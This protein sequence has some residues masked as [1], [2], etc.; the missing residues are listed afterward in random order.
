MRMLCCNFAGKLKVFVL[1]KCNDTY[2]LTAI[3]QTV[4]RKFQTSRTI[5]FKAT[6][7]REDFLLKK[8]GIP[9]GYG[10]IYRAPM[11]YYLTACNYMTTFSFITFHQYT[12]SC[13]N[14]PL[15]IAYLSQRKTIP[16]HV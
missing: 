11:E 16:R 13:C 9:P 14:K 8:D 1:R 7:K 6:I 4:K 10:I 2:A 15:S 5:P 12:Y 3:V